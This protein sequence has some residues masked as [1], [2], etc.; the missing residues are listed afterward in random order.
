MKP[1]IE[2][3]DNESK[4][5]LPKFNISSSDFFR[6]YTERE[7]CRTGILNY[8]ASD[9]RGGVLLTSSKTINVLILVMSEIFDRDL[10]KSVVKSETPVASNRTTKSTF[11]A[12]LVIDKI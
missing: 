12:V 6:D 8:F 2:I 7:N 1:M 10:C 9:R 5:D 4:I 11:P 3:F